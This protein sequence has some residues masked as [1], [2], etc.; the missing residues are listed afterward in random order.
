MPEH[1]K[2]KAASLAN[3]H[4]T[5]GI[6]SKCRPHQRIGLHAYLLSTSLGRKQDKPGSNKQYCRDPADIK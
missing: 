5:S 1:G 6:R 2:F 3:D 4:L